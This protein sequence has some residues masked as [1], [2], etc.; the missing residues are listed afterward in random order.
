[1]ST[2]TKLNSIDY[3][4][5]EAF[6]IVESIKRG[7]ADLREHMVT[8]KSLNAMNK[9]SNMNMDLLKMGVLKSDKEPFLVGNDQVDEESDTPQKS[10]TRRASD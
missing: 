9:A 3:V 4:V 1:M 2:G 5:K 6:E 10:N 7:K 8:I